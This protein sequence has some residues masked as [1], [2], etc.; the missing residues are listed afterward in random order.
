MPRRQRELIATFYLTRILFVLVVLGTIARF[1]GF[2]IIRF[3]G[4]IKDELLIVLGTSSSETV[5]PHM[6][7]KMERLGASKSVVGLVIPTGYS[8]NLD[9]TNIYMTLST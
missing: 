6:I 4:Y 8:V 5:L 1:A 2:S 9:G 3:L 7:R